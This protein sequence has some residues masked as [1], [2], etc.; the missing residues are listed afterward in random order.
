MKFHQMY[1]LR[2]GD[3]IA[4]IQPQQQAVTMKI[5]N[6]RLVETTH[7]IELEKD[8][9]GFIIGINALYQKKMF[10]SVSKKDCAKED[11]SPEK[12]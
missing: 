9:L 7:N 12:N 4:I 1:G 5:S 8:A 10:R 11:N 3:E 6:G 2:V